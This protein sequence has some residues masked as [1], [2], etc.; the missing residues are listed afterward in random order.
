MAFVVSLFPG[1]QLPLAAA[2]ADVGYRD[3]S[4]GTAVSAPTSDKPQSK[5]WFNDGSWWASLFNP[6]TA[7]YEIFRFNWAANTWATTGVPI[8]ARRKAHM[9]VLWDGSHLYV[10][11]AGTSATTSSDSVNVSRYSYDATNDTYSLDAGYPVVVVSGGTAAVVIDVD[12]TG[13]LWLTYTRENKVWVAHSN[14]NASSWSAPY[15]LPLSGAANLLSEDISAIVQFNGK[16]GVMWSNQNDSAM[17]F[18]VHEDGAADSAWTV[19]AAI[20]GPEYADNHINLKSLQADPAGQ[21]FAAVKTSLN[22]DDAPLLLLLILD[23]KG[24]WQRRTFG[25]VADSH[26]RPLVL[27]DAEDRQLYMF[28]AAPCCSGGTIYY[29]Q[30]SLDNPNFSTGVGTP[31][32]SLASDPKLNNPASTK[33]VLNSATGLLVIAGDDGTRYYAH[34]R[35]DL[36]GTTPPDTYIDSGPE[37]TVPLRDATFTFSSTQSDSTFECR[38]DSAP[39]SA[40]SSPVSYSQLSTGEHTFVVRAIREGT[41]DPTPATR[42]WTVD[43][44]TE[45]VGLAAAADAEVFS[46][47]PTTN[48][49]TAALMAVDAK[50]ASEA[51][52]KFSVPNYERQIVGATLRIF[53]ASHTVKGPDVYATGTGWTETGITWNNRPGRVGGSLDSTGAIDPDT[54]VDYDVSSAVTGPGTHSFALVGTSSDGV[55]FE[56][57]D[58]SSTSKPQLVVQLSSLDASPPETTIDSGPSGVVVSDSAT[59]M[60]SSNEAGATFECQLD[61]GAFGAC[62]SPATYSGLADGMHTFAVRAIDPSGNVDASPASA[63]WTV[64]VATDTTAPSVELTAPDDGALVAGTIALS[65]DAVDDV[66]IARVDFLVDD[67]VVASDDRAPYTSSWDTA[68]V[69]DGARTLTAL[70]VDTSNNTTTSAP[71]TV[72]VDN[73]APETTI[74]GGPS[75]IVTNTTATFEFSASEPGATFECRLDA[76]SYAACASPQTYD[77]VGDG[78]HTFAVRAIDAAGNPDASPATQLWSVDTGAS[79]FSDGFESGDFAAWSAVNTGADGTATVQ[80]T[81]TTAGSFAARLSATSAAGSVAYAR[82]TFASNQ[83]DLTVIGDFNIQAEGA[84]NAN[85]PLLRLFNDAG[86]R[87]VSVYRQNGTSSRIW[88]THSGATYSTSGILPLNTWGH[89]EVQTVAAGSGGSTVRITLNGTT[90]YQTAAASLATNGV[91]T[92]QIGNETARQTFTLIADSIVAD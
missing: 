71:R 51:Y 11:S 59:F 2:A 66:A 49:G 57:R 75:G 8:D 53:A 12:T 7:R 82:R 38:L 52:L 20:S 90:I 10:A 14:R 30:T 91:R 16:I 39:F 58:S 33:Q 4:Y 72:S 1:P 50:P 41:P 15:V 36:G 37:G 13:T 70:A 69:G 78:D 76:G 55:D 43:T 18:A 79:L 61:G 84:T 83:T 32:I 74:D 92:I 89:L 81:F 46:G 48:L 88:V 17:Y 6:G 9:D 80:S 42:T 77:P 65:A 35:L 56:S 54:W 31:F 63:G 22:A 60:F 29:K 21:V 23:E 86:T 87:I 45:A 44:T 25:T 26:T 3:F 47:A 24:S 64:S 28:A 19:S 5:L 40:C 73:T 68:A 34:N 27:I 67:V 85:V 62:T